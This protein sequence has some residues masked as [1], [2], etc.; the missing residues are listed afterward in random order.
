[1]KRHDQRG[2]AHILEIIIIGAIVIGVTVFIAWRML[3]GGNQSSNPTANSAVQQA[4]A[5]AQCAG[6]SDNDLCKFYTSFKAQKYSTVTSNSTTSDGKTSKSTYQADGSNYH[7]T[8]TGDLTYE[9]I[10]IG[11]DLYV[12]NGN[13]W[14]KQTIPQS[15]A[16]KYNLATNSELS[17][18]EPTTDAKTSQPYYKKIDTEKCGDLTC[19]KYQLIDPANPGETDYLWFDTTDYQLRRMKMQSV[20]GAGSDSTFDYTKVTVSAPN[21]FQT[22]QANQYILPGQSEPVTVPS[23]SDLQ[24]M[25]NSAGQ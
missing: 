18:N 15:D 8:L 9:A 12:K 16:S 25:L 20:D 6:L 4:I 19:L 13:T 24:N 21:S 14:W 7:V 17:F 2:I 23:Q 22:L 10:S 3:G 11:Q 5:K 1:M